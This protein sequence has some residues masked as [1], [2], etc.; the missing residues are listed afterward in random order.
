MTAAQQSFASRVSNLQR[1]VDQKLITRKT[2]RNGRE[3]VCLLVA[4]FPEVTDSL[5]QC[6]V[7][8]LPTWFINAVPFMDDHGTVAAWDDMCKEFARCMRLAA[9]FTPEDWQTVLH[10]FVI[11]VI[12]TV[13][14]LCPPA[15]V[16]V[17]T[18]FKQQLHPTLLTD[19]KTE[20]TIIAKIND[21]CRKWYLGNLPPPSIANDERMF[22]LLK[23]LVLTTGSD[24]D[25]SYTASM[26]VTTYRSVLGHREATANGLPLPVV[27][28][29]RE[30]GADMLT[31]QLLQTI[32]TVAEELKAQ[33]SVT[34]QGDIDGKSQDDNE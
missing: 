13:S 11:T 30:R 10:R 22:W 29:D 2:F 34:M 31:N 24:Q 28:V 16:D 5:Q 6:P 33:Q 26:I 7:G 27:S 19:R 15:V 20:L 12:D 25:F 23:Q 8:Y 21:V 1:L 18:E 14:E 17:L 4:M 3:R 32:A 9:D